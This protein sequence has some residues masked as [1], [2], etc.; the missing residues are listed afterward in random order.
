MIKRLFIA[1]A[2]AASVWVSPAAGARNAATA[3]D[4]STCNQWVRIIDVSSNNRVNNWLSVASQGIAG[5]YVKA[6][7]G[8][9]YVNPDQASQIKGANA[10]GLLTGGYDFAKTSDDPVADAKFFVIHGGALGLLPPALDLEVTRVSTQATIKWALTWLTE[11]KKLTVRTPILYTG[12]VYSWSHSA[13]LAQAAE[14]WIAAYPYGYNR[15]PKG[16]FC[17]LPQPH[18]GAWH[19]WSLWQYTSVGRLSGITGHVDVDAVSTVWWKTVTGASVAPPVAPGKRPTSYLHLGSNGPAVVVV[20]NKLRIYGFLS[21]AADGYYGPITSAAVV[22][23]QKAL[24][25]PVTGIWDNV[26]ATKA[27]QYFIKHTPPKPKP[28]PKIP[29]TCVRLYL[30]NGSSGACVVVLQKLLHVSA[31]GSF[32]RA[33]GGAVVR[34]QTLHHLYADGTVGPLTWKELAA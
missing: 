3:L 21:G 29:A 17:S 7:E 4:G 15:I 14:L 28:V 8:L 25:L 5:A 11:V 20:Q 18:I 22:R 34:F 24:H 31:D 10:A 27:A 26:T 1:T 32:G 16:A 12:G 30:A 33:T 9:D 13:T 23:V 6:T 19:G 2:I